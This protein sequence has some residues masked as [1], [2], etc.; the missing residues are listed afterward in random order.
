MSLLKIGETSRGEITNR[1]GPMDGY[2]SNVH[3]GYYRL[4]DVTR[5]SLW[6]G[7]GIIP[8]G[9]ST[10]NWTD[11]VFLRFDSDDRIEEI[12]TVS[13]INETAAGWKYYAE[14]WPAKTK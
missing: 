8:V 9:T 7:L 10:L 11:A 5:R 3:V 4:T 14:T 1:Y 2:F 13:R 12:E 6:L